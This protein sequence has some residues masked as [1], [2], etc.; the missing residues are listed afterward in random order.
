[1]T[2][3]S[4]TLPDEHPEHLTSCRVEKTYH[5]PPSAGGSPKQPQPLNR[6]GAVVPKCAIVTKNRTPKSPRHQGCRHS[7]APQ[8]S[9]QEQVAREVVNH[10]KLDVRNPPPNRQLENSTR[11]PHRIGLHERAKTTPTP[12]P[13]RTL[14]DNH[15]ENHDSSD[16]AQGEAERP[17]MHV[18]L[19]A[20]FKIARAFSL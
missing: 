17:T 14:D 12:I 8:T 20:R 19:F 9:L 18:R 11:E 13:A 3:P 15:R 10:C 1:M 4:R 7:R 5:R 6:R 16:S 2:L